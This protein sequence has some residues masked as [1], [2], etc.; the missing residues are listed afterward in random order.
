LRASVDQVITLIQGPPGT[1]KTTTAVEIILEWLR[2]SNQII[3]VCAETDISIDK[4][5]TELD[6]A[7]IRAVRVGLKEEAGGLNQSKNISSYTNPN[8]RNNNLKRIV[9]EAQVPLSQK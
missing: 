7:R 6:R 2:K 9:S 5:L 4:M 3:L 1:G 8:F